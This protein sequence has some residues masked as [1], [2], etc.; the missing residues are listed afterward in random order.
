MTRS[1][2]LCS[3]FLV[4][5][6]HGCNSDPCAPIA[7][8]C[9]SARVEGSVKVDQ[10]SIEVGAPVNRS[11][12]TPI[13]ARPLSLPIEVGIE[14]PN[15]TSG[16][17]NITILGESSGR[18]I[19]TSGARAVAILA[20][21]HTQQTFVLS[22][23]GSI[24]SPDLSIVSGQ[25]NDGG[26]DMDAGTVGQPDLS[27]DAGAGVSVLQFVA[28]QLGGPGNVDGTGA[29]GRFTNPEGIT[30]DGNGHLFVADISSHTIRKF[31]IASGAVTTVAGT[32]GI[33]GN[34]DGVG[35]QA[36]F[37]GPEDLAL[38]GA[39]N[40]YV[41]D[42]NN[43]SIRKVVLATGAVSTIISGATLT[44]HPSGIVFDATSNSLYF[45]ADDN[46]LSKLPVGGATPTT[47]AGASGTAGTTDSTSGTT[48][49]FS[50]PSHIANDGAGN[51]FICDTGNDTVRQYIIGTTEVRTVAGTPGTA[52]SGNGSPGTLN[53]P[54]GVS[55]IGNATL[56]VAD[57]KNQMLRAVAIGTKTLSSVV[58][59]AGLSGSDDGMGTAARFNLP[60]GIVMSGAMA[61]VA[62]NAN[63]T[64]RSV[65]T[66]FMQTGT[67]AGAAP[68]I[69]GGSADG[70]GSAARFSYPTDIAVD[71]RV[72]F[73]LPI[74]ATTR[75]ANSSG[76][77]SLHWRAHLAWPAL[78]I[79]QTELGLQ[80]GL[81]IL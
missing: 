37:N 11:Q 67:V 65:Q 38:D 21:G 32:A 54:R 41:C 16:S 14:L 60:G 44:A 6:L 15:G 52:G 81:I 58:G 69:P 40:L 10:L 57:T 18:V 20:N 17:L 8:A 48:A 45:T 39:G 2:S 5:L 70:T 42:Y 63:G 78:P 75:F 4:L 56:L 22:D 53:A 7:G 66:T 71:C 68:I 24:G 59:A 76:T 29:S 19:A 3:A 26:G 25:G 80:R 43:R 33:S 9:I 73:L 64:I 34:V 31:D 77:S 23:Q 13:P 30:S 12:L 49:R 72:I 1:V 61:Y 79:V 35:R 51:L 47:V 74:L 27:L 28:G 46:T 36:R 62:D 50:A 55:Y